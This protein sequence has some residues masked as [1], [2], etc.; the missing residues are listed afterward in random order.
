[1]RETGKRIVTALVCAVLL[2]CLLPVTAWAGGPKASLQLHIKNPDRRECCGVLLSEADP[3]EESFGGW[4]FDRDIL[5]AFMNYRD[6]DGFKISGKNWQCDEDRSLVFGYDLPRTFKILIYYPDTGEFLASGVLKCYAY[7]SVFTVDLAGGS[8]TVRRSYSYLRSVAGALAL[9]V[10]AVAIELMVALLYGYRERKLLRLI[11]LVNMA[12]QVALSI[13]LFFINY[14]EG[15][16]AFLS[17]YVLLGV[18]VCC[19]ETAV[20]RRIFPRAAQKEVSKEKITS[21]AL[22]ANVCSVL[23]GVAFSWFSELLF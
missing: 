17:S 1:M 14:L 18:V 8:M 21:Y 15:P 9:L 6:H 16:L 7:D 23:F 3:P 19:V 13:A 4:H 5:Q 20:Y 22:T 12:T 11:A 10:S 2:I